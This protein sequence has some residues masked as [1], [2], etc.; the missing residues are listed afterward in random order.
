M[1]RRR[2]VDVFT[3]SF[4]DCIACGFGAVILFFFIINHSAEVR[5]DELN[6]ELL[7]QAEQLEQQLL[8]GE[9]NRVRLRNSL[10]EIEARQVVSQGRSR[11]IIHELEQTEAELAELNQETTAR[12][13]HIAQ[14]V[15]DVQAAEAEAKRLEGSV[16]GREDQGD[17]IRSFTG[18]GDRQYLTGLKVGG[19]R[20]LI[21]ID[22]SASMLDDTIVNIIRRRN[23]P[24]AQKL[25]APKWQRVIAA[26]DWITAQ[27]PIGSAFQIYTFN[28]DVVPL[29]K[30]TA[31]KWQTAEH[32]RGLNKAIENLRAVVPQAGT[33]L[34]R[35]LAVVTKLEPRP[36]T[37]YLLTDGLPTQ[38]EGEPIEGTV[39]GEA[40]LQLF[41]EAVEDLPLGIPMNVILFPLEGDPMAASAYWQLA[42]VTRG[43]FLS[44]SRDWP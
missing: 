14:L 3:L 10:A 5:S 12:R 35:A 17:E 7:A 1:A 22:A 32:G 2:R 34:H 43:A 23:L 20:I 31:G 26:A 44:P 18:Q 16:A 37:V 6:S 41:A 29:L 8:A 9:K 28:V 21:L 24:D 25:A 33:S 15:A 13:E 40:R 36:D 38:G 42:Q 27:I 4:L 30:G 19:E 39:S 11:Q